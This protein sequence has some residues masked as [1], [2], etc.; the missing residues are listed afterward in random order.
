MVVETD[1]RRE[2]PA[3][4]D[5]VELQVDQVDRIGNGRHIRIDESPVVSVVIVSPDTDGSREVV[6]DLAGDVQL[7]AIDVL[8]TL[9][10][11]AVVVFVGCH[12]GLCQQGTDGYFEHGDALVVFHEATATHDADHRREGPHVFLVGGKQGRHDGRRGYAVVLLVEIG[13]QIAWNADLDVAVL[14]GLLEVE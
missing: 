7:S 12:A 1:D 8:L 11:G 10:V 2:A 5:A 6:V 14:P 13:T 3:A 4:L 9:H